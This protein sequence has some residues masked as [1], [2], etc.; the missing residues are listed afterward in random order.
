MDNVDELL[1]GRIKVDEERIPS[2]MWGPSFSRY[3]MKLKL[4]LPL[5]FVVP[6][7]LLAVHRSYFIVVSIVDSFQSFLQRLDF[8]PDPL[9]LGA[10]DCYDTSYQCR[11]GYVRTDTMVEPYM[12]R[13]YDMKERSDKRILPFCPSTHLPD[14]ILLQQRSRRAVAEDPRAEPQNLRKPIRA[15]RSREPGI[16]LWTVGTATH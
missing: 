16:I 9:N 1:Q 3:P 12:T 11:E 15:S 2:G 14:P 6:V 10:I 13:S 5:L 8:S 7:L 4:F